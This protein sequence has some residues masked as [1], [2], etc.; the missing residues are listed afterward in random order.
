MKMSKPELPAAT[1]MN[2][3]NI[4]LRGKKQ[5]AREHILCNDGTMM[6][7]EQGHVLFR[8]GK[9]VRWVDRWIDR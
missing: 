9:I 8:D 7:L 6:T 3:I 2:L 4:I 1:W 5:I